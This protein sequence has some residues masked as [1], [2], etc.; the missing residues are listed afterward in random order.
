[1]PCSH[2]NNCTNDCVLVYPM[3]EWTVRCFW[4]DRPPYTKHSLQSL[5]PKFQTSCGPSASYPRIVRSELSRLS[6]K[7]VKI[8]NLNFEVGIIPHN[9]FSNQYESL[10]LLN[11]FSFY[12]MISNY[13]FDLNFIYLW[14]WS[15]SSTWSTKISAKTLHNQMTLYLFMS[16]FFLNSKP[17]LWLSTSYK[18]ISHLRAFQS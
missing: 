7:L 17:N 8:L 12:Q 5:R 11:S 4:E 6:R 14:V 1:M 15:W 3:L 2:F 18:H 10:E 16:Y 9:L 13:F